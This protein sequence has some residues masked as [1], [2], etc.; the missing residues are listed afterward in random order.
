MPDFKA[1]VEQISYELK[2]RGMLMATAESCTGG[3]VAA[4]ITAR[5]G[6]SS[7]FDRGFVTYSY[8]SKEELLN[9]SREILEKHGAV[10]RECAAAMAHGTLDR[11][12]ADLAISITGIA[13]PDGGMEGKPV[14]LVYIGCGLRDGPVEVQEHHFPGDR[15]EVRAHTVTAALTTA[16]NTLKGL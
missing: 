14:G 1:L 10:S 15:D 3:M 12:W 13:G 7:V 11:S 4:A 8:E 16:L 2:M 9:V 5:P 6:S